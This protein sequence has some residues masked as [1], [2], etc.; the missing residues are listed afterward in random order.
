MKVTVTNTPLASSTEEA[1]YIQQMGTS[2]PNIVS[3]AG[4]G[5]C[6]LNQLATFLDVPETHLIR[7]F[8]MGYAHARLDSS[9]SRPSRAP[10]VNE[11]YES[12]DL[13]VEDYG[14]DADSLLC[15]VILEKLEGLSFETY[16]PS[17]DTLFSSVL[18]V[19]NAILEM[20]RQEL[21][22]NDLHTGNILTSGDDNRPVI[23]DFDRATSQKY[24]S[25]LPEGF[26]D[27]G[28]TNE[29]MA[30]RDMLRF[31]TSVVDQLGVGPVQSKLISMVRP[32]GVP[33]N[34]TP[35]LI[36]TYTCKNQYLRDRMRNFRSLSINMSNNK[37]EALRVLLSTDSIAKYIDSAHF[38]NELTK[39]VDSL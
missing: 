35:D 4:T 19:V 13:P 6:A 29:F 25:H 20:E 11:A 30:G 10:L 9:W 23:I 37:T 5:V 39:Y 18:Q 2:H 7:N 15:F 14:I 38:G 3:V 31:I 16:L 8:T 28:Q 27:Y 22:H 26:D 17:Q 32:S 36:R 24:P 21:N 33:A 34:I 1:A 12:S